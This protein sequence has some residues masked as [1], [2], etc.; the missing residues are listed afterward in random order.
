MVE[1]YK[2]HVAASLVTH[3]QFS[4]TVFCLTMVV[5]RISVWSLVM[6]RPEPEAGDSSGC[7]WSTYVFPDLGPFQAVPLPHT[8]H[9]FH[10]S[11]NSL[12]SLRQAILTSLSL[13]P[14]TLWVA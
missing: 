14:P 10:Q 3:G 2:E 12:S 4:P 13:P 9:P 1:F 8:P 11:G 6:P 5:H 7:E